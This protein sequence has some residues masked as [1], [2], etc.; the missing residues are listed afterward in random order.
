MGMHWAKAAQHTCSLSHTVVSTLETN[1]GNVRK[2]VSH[3]ADAP[4]SVL[5]GF[6]PSDQEIAVL[7]NEAMDTQTCG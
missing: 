7:L 6:D 5:T 4:G 3:P 2:L 1:V